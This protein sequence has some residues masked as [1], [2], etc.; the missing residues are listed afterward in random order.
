MAQIIVRIMT[1]EDEAGASEAWSSA[2]ETLRQTYRPIAGA[3]DD[4]KAPGELTSIVAIVN[5]RMR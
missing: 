3:L 4:W 2:M 5:G 1:H